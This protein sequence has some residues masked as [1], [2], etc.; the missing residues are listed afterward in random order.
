M[1]RNAIVVLSLCLGF[2]L[3]SGAVHGQG[4]YP[5]R[6][7]E[8][9]IPWNPG[10]VSDVTGRIFINELSKILNVSIIPVNKPG[11]GGTLGVAFSHNA[12]K[13]GYTLLYGSVG[14]LMGAASLEKVP[15]DPLNDF[16]PIAMIC[17]A[18]YS[19]FVKGDS[20]FKTYEDLRDKAK[21]NP[22]ALSIGCVLNGDVHL[23]I[24]IL[25][26]A[27]GIEFNIVPFKG[28]AETATAV[29]GG[30][31]DS[32]LTITT[33]PLSYAKAGTLR[34][35]AQTGDRR[36]KYLP[37]VPTFKEKGLTQTFLDKNWNGL[38]A[39]AGVARQMVD[40]LVQASEK[41]LQSK[42]LVDNMD[43]V[44][45]A[46]DYMGGPEFQRKVETDYRL[47]ENFVTQLG[48]KGK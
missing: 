43:K 7:I 21:K 10:G 31:L 18:N 45:Y 15:F 19:L 16:I 48:L 1:R 40:R 30:H 46:V 36:M 23:N 34:I 6:N 39:P 3:I 33:N 14:H 9:V 4:T 8:V 20:P 32:G 28:G 37:D 11:A 47:I 17:N 27:A 29:I 2:V 12:K 35:L 41:A 38:F 24:E 42:E 5:E 44:A 26:K 13:D 22:K 25:Q